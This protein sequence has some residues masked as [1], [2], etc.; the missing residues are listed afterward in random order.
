MWDLRTFAQLQ[1]SEMSSRLLQDFM[2]EY[3]KFLR[4]LPLLVE[5]WFPVKGT[6]TQQ[7]P[8]QWL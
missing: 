6:P 2:D 3:I 7:V 1:V 4:L 8:N 5:L